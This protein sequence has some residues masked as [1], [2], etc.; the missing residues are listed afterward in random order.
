MDLEKLVLPLEVADK[1]FNKGLAVAAAGVT[2]L[3]GAMGVAIKA[4]FDW[5][6]ELDSIGDVMD[7]TNEQAAAFGY[8]AR[9]SGVATE[10][11]TKGV[12]I[13]SKGLVKA[14]GSL[15]TTGK[16]LESWGISVKDANG[17]LKSQTALMGDIA[18]KYGSFATQQEKVNFLTETFGKSGA[19]LVDFFD[20]LAKEG[21]MDAVTEKVKA[22]GLAIDPARY[23]TFTRNLEELKLIGTG[24][25]VTFTETLMPALENI[26]GWFGNFAAAD[27]AQKMQMM[28][29]TIH[30][31][32][33]GLFNLTDMFKQGAANIDWAG[34]STQLA[35]GINNI[36]W[37]TVGIYFRGGILNVLQGIETIVSEIDWEALKVALGG[38]VANLTAGLFGYTD[39]AALGVD[40]NKG[41]NSV[42]SSLTN[43]TITWQGFVDGLKAIWQGFLDFIT[44]TKAQATATPG[45]GVQGGASPT[46]GG[47]TTAASNLLVTTPGRN[48]Q[49]GSFRDSGGP[50]IA[51][52]QYKI[53]L[54]ETFTPATN[55]RIEPMGGNSSEILKAIQNNRIDENRLARA[56]VIALKQGMAT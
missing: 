10:T 18:K 26:M 29:D 32:L 37:N 7:V 50:V 22:F 36:D 54:P 40:F 43:F 33:G 21:G 52:Q 19:E 46:G 49:G 2:A 3:V 4:T 30:D 16:S 41:I 17:Q 27:P 45:R 51:G 44:A 6:G 20:V 56:I 14:D 47:N 25:A 55:G 24:L 23:E 15:D 13:L 53:G 5:A 9:K 28:K 34:L 48:V 1:A 31:A 35:D 38:A 11:F 12:V 8:I 42:F 39:W